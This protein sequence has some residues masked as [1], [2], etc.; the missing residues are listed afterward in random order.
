MC[1]VS[2]GLTCDVY[3]GIP[4]V[5][6]SLRDY[7]RERDAN[8]ARRNWSSLCWN[9]YVKIFQLCGYLRTS[10]SEKIK[11]RFGDGFKEKKKKKKELWVMQISWKE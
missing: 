6:N 9:L 10:Q 8:K 11:S 5:C 3:L 7:Q 2:G 4:I 1:Y